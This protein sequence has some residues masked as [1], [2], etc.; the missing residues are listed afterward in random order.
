MAETALAMDS[1]SCR[2][3]WADGRTILSTYRGRLFHVA[4][5]RPDVLGLL[6]GYHTCNEVHLCQVWKSKD[7]RH[8]QRNEATDKQ[9][10]L[11]TPS[12]EDLPN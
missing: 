8:G 5:N 1:S 3:C 2:F 4:G 10:V 11:W 12:K 6:Y 9:N 7:A